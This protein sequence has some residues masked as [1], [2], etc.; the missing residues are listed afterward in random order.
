MPVVALIVV[1][2]DDGRLTVE[3]SA[4]EYGQDSDQLGGPA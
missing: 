3:V 2:W 1:G 4:W